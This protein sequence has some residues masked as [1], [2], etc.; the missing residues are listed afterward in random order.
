ML[1]VLAIESW[2]W[3][4]YEE[5]FEIGGEDGIEERLEACGITADRTADCEQRVP[6]YVHLR[7]VEE[8]LIIQLTVS[9]ERIF[10]KTGD[11]FY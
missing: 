8:Q 9:N 10:L 4:F 2:N 11:M 7:R 3:G 6:V 5:R 1:I